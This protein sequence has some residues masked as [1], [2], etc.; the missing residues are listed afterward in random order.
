MLDLSGNPLTMGGDV[1]RRADAHA[2]AHAG[3]RADA[4]AAAHDANHE[5]THSGGYDVQ[6]I[7]LVCRLLCRDGCRLETLRL[8]ATELCGTRCASES[9]AYSEAHH[10]AHPRSAAHSTDGYSA[11]GAALLIEAL[12]S[13]GAPRLSKVVLSSNAMRDT[14]AIA[15]SAALRRRDGAR[16]CARMRVD[17]SM[18][19]LSR[20]ALSC[21]RSACAHAAGA[22]QRP[23]CER[24]IVGLD[25]CIYGATADDDAVYLAHGSG[26]I[27]KLCSER[28]RETAR[29]EGHSDDTNCI[30]LHGTQFLVSGSDDFSVRL[31]RRHGGGGAEGKTQTRRT[32]RPIATHPPI[33]AHPSPPIPT[34][35]PTHPH[36][37]KGELAQSAEPSCVA[38][39][40]GH[41]ARVWCVTADESRIFSCGADRSITV[42]CAAAARSGRA[43]QLAQLTGSKPP[44]VSH[45]SPILVP[46]SAVSLHVKVSHRTPLHHGS[47]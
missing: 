31:W 16:N 18:N 36:P 28:W 30:C 29:F 26:A 23:L 24:A 2:D 44:K 35:P 37:P 39:L 7:A 20:S 46:W 41:E 9:T 14:E 17:V 8:E 38:T 13:G 4:R 12:R 1:V 3:G 47:I 10:E 45:S 22:Y 21:L 6:A 42:W 27:V 11:E 19:A 43:L 5:D 33:P 25:K 34:H 32:H 40:A 15:L